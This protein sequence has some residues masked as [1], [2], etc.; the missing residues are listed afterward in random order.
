MCRARRDRDESQAIEEALHGDSGRSLTW[1]ERSCFIRVSSQMQR[2]L[3]DSGALMWRRHGCPVSRF[4]SDE[5]ELAGRE[6]RQARDRV[7]RSSTVFRL[8]DGCA[9]SDRSRCAADQPEGVFARLRSFFNGRP[10]RE[11]KSAVFVDR[12]GT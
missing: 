3:D 11:L 2:A 10:T 8:T 1:W 6:F 9:M 4:R 5:R 12:A 7:S